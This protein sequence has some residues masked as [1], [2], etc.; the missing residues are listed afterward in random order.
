MS[1]GP[2]IAGSGTVRVCLSNLVQ[3]S[4]GFLCLWCPLLLLLVLPTLCLSVTL[5][6]LRVLARQ[7]SGP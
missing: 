7:V 6:L 5:Q 4:A 1:A 3:I 2:R